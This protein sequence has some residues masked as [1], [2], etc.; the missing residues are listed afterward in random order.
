[1]IEIQKRQVPY[2]RFPA[3]AVDLFVAGGGV[4]FIFDTAPEYAAPHG[5]AVDFHF[6]AGPYVA[7]VTSHPDH[8]YTY[9]AADAVNFQRVQVFEPTV[10][11]Q[12]GQPIFDKAIRDISRVQPWGVT[13]KRDHDGLHPWGMFV[14]LD[15]GIGVVIPADPQPPTDE[16]GTILIPILRAYV[17]LNH[18]TLLRV[19]NSL[20]L[21]ALDLSIT[22]DADSWTFSWSAIVPGNKL[23]DVL[24]ASPGQPVEFGATINSWQYRLLAERVSLDNRFGQQRVRIEGRGIAALLAAPYL[25]DETRSNAQ[26]RAASQL[27]GDALLI[28]N[29][30]ASGWTVDFGLTDW[31]VPAGAWR[32]YGTPIDALGAIARAGGGYLRADPTNKR[33]EVVPRYP[34]KPWEWGGAT[35]DFQLPASATVKVGVEWVENPPFNAV[36]VGGTTTSAVLA[37]VRRAGTAG[38]VVAP[39]QLDPLIVAAQAARQRGEAVLGAA[40]S[41][42]RLSLETPVLENIGPYHV[43]SLI[44]FVDGGSGRVGLVRS[45]RISAAMPRVRQTLEVECHE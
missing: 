10:D 9:P 38:D 35:P 36:Y 28:N 42:Q 19:E 37:L 22:A 34:V 6:G 25:A 26:E 30:P 24:P 32:H 21:H 29:V 13:A 45:N 8:A 2:V 41:T 5:H 33:I 12:T 11:P 16:H 40:G 20:A 7:P 4:D 15:S 18:V 14:R 1:M 27:C 23:D 43:G 31:L 17:M 3:R 39:M 44:R